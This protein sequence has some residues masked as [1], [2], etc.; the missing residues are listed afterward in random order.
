MIARIWHGTVP[1]EKATEY[2]R[3]MRT[4]ALPDYR[5]IPGNRAAFVLRR[6]EGSDT[7]FITLTFWDSE[8]AIREF[9][10]ENIDTAKYYDFD[11]DFLLDLEPHVKHYELY[12]D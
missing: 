6:V 5:S 7:H 4:I 1:N 12:E 2:L 8:Q 10:G 9:A 11:T 3:R